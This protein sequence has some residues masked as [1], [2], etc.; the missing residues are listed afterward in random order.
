M[1]NISDADTEVIFEYTGEGCAVPKNVTI[2]RFHPSVTEVEDEA[3]YCC[4]SLCE[5]VLNDGLQKIRIGAFWNCTSLSSIT[6]P[7]TI[8]EIGQYAFR[9]CNNLREVALNEGLQKIGWNAF[10]DCTSLSSIT[11]PSTVTEIGSGAFYNCKQLIEVVFNEGLQKIGASAFCNCTSLSSMT[12]PSAVTEIGGS[13]FSGCKHLNEVVLNDGLQKIGNGAFSRCTLLS[14]IK[15][16]STV[17]DIGSDAFYSCSNL[18]EVI[19]HGVPMVIGKDVFY[20]TSLKRFA[21]PTISSRLD[22][23]IQTGHWEEIENEVNE[24]RGVVQ[25]SGGELFVLVTQSMRMRLGNNW[26]V[27]RKDLDKIVR[28]IS[29]YELKEA[30]SIFELALWKFKLGQVDKANPIPRKK[31]RMDAPG[32]VKDIILQYLR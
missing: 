8:T 4:R 18:R 27:V 2:V 16:P 20:N 15:L 24:V 6:L 25:R 10:Y 21:F 23:L 29:Y 5:V 7:Y 26:N 22:T 19:W 9:G 14:S 1:P 17:N 11:L 13:T 28:L 31:C 32:P 30:T 12:L 3:F